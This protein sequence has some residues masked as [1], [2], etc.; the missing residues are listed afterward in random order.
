[1]KTYI[2]V[3]SIVRSVAV[4]VLVSS[5][6][7]LTI[8]SAWSSAGLQN[9]RP[10]VMCWVFIALG[11]AVSLVNAHLSFVRP[12]LYARRHGRSLVGYRFVSGVPLIG[13]ILAALAVLAA[14]GHLLVAVLSLLLLLTD[15][16]GVV[17]LLVALSRGRSFW[18][19]KRVA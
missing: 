5:P 16:G 1:M 17:S 14:W 18:R 7:A 10:H 11:A 9:E 8:L 3:G 4:V 12:M 19:S 13:S 15:T 6:I 2:P